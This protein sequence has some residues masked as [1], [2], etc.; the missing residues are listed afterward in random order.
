[1]LEFEFAMEA[2]IKF[3]KNIKKAESG[4]FPLFVSQ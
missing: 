2:I 1:M 3:V 4:M